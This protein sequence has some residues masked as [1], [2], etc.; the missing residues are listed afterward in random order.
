MASAA[1]LFSLQEIDLA[2]DHARDRLVVIEEEIQEPD[3]LR[4]LRQVQEEKESVVAGLRSRQKDAED[5]VEQVR[6]KANQIE[7]KLYSGKVT[8]PKELTDLNDDLRSLKELTAKREDRLLTLLVETEEAD[9]DLSS[10]KSRLSAAAGEWQARRDQLLA[11]EREL[12][13]EVERLQS[14]REAAVAGIDPASLKL[15]QLLRERKAGQAVAHVERGMCG[16]CRIT[17]PMS[18]LQKARSGTDLTQCV[19]CERIL[20]VT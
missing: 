20:L 8:S 4:E 2:L 13:P 12:K 17:L 14:S 6:S 5:E 15:Y 1:D 18:V 7:T 10:T 16:G 11:E 9:G 19:S 3:E